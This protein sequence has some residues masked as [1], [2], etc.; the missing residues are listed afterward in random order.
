M[1]FLFTIAVCLCALLVA[2]SVVYAQVTGDY[3]SNGTGNW[4]DHTKWLS[5]NGSSWVAAATAPTGSG[6]ITL[7]G[8]DSLYLDV[9]VT[10]TG[11]LRTTGGKVGN[12]L[13]TLSF[14]PGSVYEHAI[15]AGSIP[16]AAWDSTSTI[17]ISG[18]VTAGPQFSSGTQYGNVDFE[19][20]GLTQNVQLNMTGTSV[21]FRGHL[22][23]GATTSAAGVAQQLRLSG[24]SATYPSLYRTYYIGGDLIM[25]STRSIF[26][27]C[28][29]GTAYTGDS[30]YVGGNIHIN[31]GVFSINRG[32]GASGW[33]FCNGDFSI[34]AGAQVTK[35]SSS[36]Y[37]AMIFFTKSGR[38]TF[39]NQGSIST[40]FAKPFDV[41]VESGSIFNTG[42]GQLTG[43]MNFTL[44]QGATLETARDGGVDSAIVPN[45]GSGTG[46]TKT[47]EPN[48]S[49]IFDGSTPQRTGTLMPTTV[50]DLIINNTAGVTLTQA[51]TV[52]DT[53]YLKAGVF[54]NTIPF[55][56]AS[57]AGIAY[58]GGSLLIPLGVKPEG[59]SAIPKVF[60]VDQNY[61]NP[62][63]P[64]T[65]VRFGLPTRSS[66]S[67]RV[68]NLLGQ[69]V[70]TVFEGTR[71]AG[72][73]N[74]E[75]D[76]SALPSGIYLC[77]IQA[78]RNV[79]VKRMLLVR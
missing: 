57:G 61:P 37:P 59:G 26:T 27:F 25:D 46:V 43:G 65:T 6:T 11:K 2:G 34:G 38:Q 24:S 29:S 17:L 32:S 40:G 22:W 48:S 1:K 36:N 75:F 47:F 39:T 30:V 21:T 73:Y 72:I 54:D 14:G 45:N 69:E 28:G 60:F 53:L 66:V 31:A 42:S 10:I 76:A 3:Q 20:H 23:V 68:Y 64:S 63:N 7:Q 33:L 35:H 79:Q 77:R 5:Y 44:K 51:T 49:F 18:T 8:T 58:E 71:P 74:L 55:T 41:F 15:D 19:S 70:A 56:L 62:F 9:S 52:T 12:S 13:L 4:S 78:G 16:D 50:W 67:A